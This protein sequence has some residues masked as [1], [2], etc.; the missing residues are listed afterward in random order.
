MRDCK[1][2]HPLLSDYLDMLLSPRETGRVE[3]HLKDCPDARKELAGLRRLR[4]VM[5]ALPEPKPPHGLHERI[6]AKVQGRPVPV[7]PHRPFWVLPTGVLAVAAMVTV[8]LMVQNPGMMNFENTKRLQA[9]MTRQAATPGT[10]SLFIAG[11]AKPQTNLSY[12]YAPQEAQNK[13]GTLLE[14]DKTKGSLGI[15]YEV[16]PL[17]AAKKMQSTQRDASVD[18]AMA[19]AA[20]EAANI[21]AVSFGASAQTGALGAS[22]GGSATQKNELGLTTNG[23]VASSSVPN[24]TT[25][26]AA[27]PASIP[28]NPTPTP[29]TSWTGSFNPSTPESQELVTDAGTFQKYWQTFQPGQTPPSVDF[30]AQAVVVLMDQE[31]PTAGYSV[32]VTSLED[33]PDQLVIHYKVETPAPGAVTAQVLTRPWALQIIPKPTKPVVFQKD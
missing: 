22:F 23:A 26:A 31:R 14:A 20:P 2:I 13:D 25:F 11:Q 3:A 24:T 15:Q 6:M 29:V 10:T 28:A 1:K 19:K 32:Q 17:H 12:D 5:V 8:I 27:P 4:E 33:K 16:S 30:T 18:L 9:P 21:P 7:S